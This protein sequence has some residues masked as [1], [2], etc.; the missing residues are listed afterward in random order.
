[1][2]IS[3]TLLSDAH[4]I[5]GHHT[6]IADEGL[7]CGIPALFHD[8]GPCAGSIY[9]KNYNYN[10][11]KIF[12]ESSDDFQLKFF[13]YFVEGRYPIG[14]TSYMESSYKKIC[15]GNVVNRINKT[16]DKIIDT[17]SYNE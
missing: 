13:N 7:C 10:E 2:D 16:I 11:S 5:I 8:F 12:S 9:A 4:A 17:N 14:V 1:M 6:L 15:D 3:Y